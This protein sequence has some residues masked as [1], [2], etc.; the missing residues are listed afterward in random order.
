MTDNAPELFTHALSRVLDR[1]EDTR[2]RVGYAFPH[3]ADT[4][5]GEWTVTADGDWT[6]G[7]WPGQMWLAALVTGNSGWADLARQAERRMAPRLTMRTAFKGFG[8]F[9]AAVMGWTL[10]GDEQC[11]QDALTCAR[12]LYEMYDDRLGL[13]P[14]GSDAE[15]SATVGTAESSVDSLQASPL[16]LWAAG[17]SADAD[18]ERVAV[19]HTTRVLDLHVRPDGS[20]IQSSTLNPADGTLIRQHTHKGYDDTSTWARA[21]AWAVLY[22]SQCYAMRPT[23]TDWLRHAKAVS[24]WWIRHV[25]PDG[26]AYWDFEDPAIPDTE[27]DTAATAITCSG[28]LKL[29]EALTDSDLEAAQR[30]LQAATVTVAALA[31][32]YLTPAGI[33]TQGCFTK[34]AGARSHDAATNV[35]LIFG[36]YFLTE[37][38]SVMCG[39]VQPSG[40]Q[41]RQT[42]GGVADAR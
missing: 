42:V 17:E 36:S 34:R 10:F 15:E 18:L 37:C 1:V 20:V 25:P 4:T 3:W 9:H 31:E 38:L 14:L 28:L 39:Y 26:V 19:Q 12:S 30:Y 27:R 22:A 24:D 41:Q 8:F 23:H 16:L 33:L 13:I 35:E 5:T 40:L 29:S 32:D 11:R 6:G 2:T 7:S 21:Q